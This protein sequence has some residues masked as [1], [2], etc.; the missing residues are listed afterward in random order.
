MKRGKRVSKK[1]QLRLVRDVVKQLTPD[2]L[3]D[4][5][6]GQCPYTTDNCTAASCDYCTRS[7]CTNSR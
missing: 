7:C 4:A 2:D 3:Q 5:N 6:G 1:E